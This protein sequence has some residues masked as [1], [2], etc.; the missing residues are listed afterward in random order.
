MSLLLIMLMIGFVQAAVTTTKNTYKNI[1]VVNARSTAKPCANLE[2]EVDVKLYIV[3]DAEW[4]DGD[5]LEDV[6]GEPQDIPNA[7]FTLKKIW[8][9]PE[10]GE[11][12]VIIDCI[13][14]EEYD[15]LE[16]TDSLSEVGFEVTAVAGTA[17]AEKGTNSI[18]DHVWGYDPEAADVVNEMLQISLTPNGEDIALEN[19]TLQSKDS[20]D[21][22]QINAVEV[23]IDENNNGRVDA[24]EGIIGDVQPAY[25]ADNGKTTII[26]D[27]ILTEGVTE[28]IIVTY[29]MQKTTP[30][31]SYAFDVVSIYGIGEESNKVIK[32]LGTP[33]DSGVKTVI[34]PKTCLGLLRFEIDPNP[35]DEGL[36]VVAKMTN[37]TECE[38]MEISVKPNP[39]ANIQ[40]LTGTCV[41]EG[42]E[43]AGCELNMP[44][45]IGG[46][47]YA[48][49]DKNN[50]G[51]YLDYGESSFVDLVI[52]IPEEP[53]EINETIEETEETEETE[54][55]EE[56]EE[57]EVTEE[58][59]TKVT[60]LEEVTGGATAA[61]SIQKLS[62]AGGFLV[63]LEVT[64]LLILFVLV[65]I[66]FRLR[67]PAVQS[68]AEGSAD[69]DNE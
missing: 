43:G 32:F 9:T 56:T 6:R 69:E 36:D 55:T 58:T 14:N 67:A 62:E 26:L 23:Y 12:D 31:G 5:V 13:E 7:K 50:D 45:P 19:I 39:C 46:R 17:S 20:G 29:T 40:T 2:D 16:P 68:V 1:E 30:E 59:E 63:L 3:E 15:T 38:G 10:V 48:C 34:A 65:M 61:D 24:D 22:I 47:Y 52:I 64:M 28:N 8:D 57:T 49:I 35:V 4:E 11:Y 33:I 53:V 60:G 37:M 54:V 21:D 51:D 41:I 18:E 66:L 42:V 44:S 27:Y 25:N